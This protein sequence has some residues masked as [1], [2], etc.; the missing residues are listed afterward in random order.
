MT[1]G[2]VPTF[3]DSSGT[4]KAASTAE[5]SVSFQFASHKLSPSFQAQNELRLFS[6]ELWSPSPSCG[7]VLHSQP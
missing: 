5:S 7:I 1:C 4:A 2:M 3:G 6:P